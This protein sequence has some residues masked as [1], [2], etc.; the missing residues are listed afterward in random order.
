MF[1]DVQ[2][3]QRNIHTN[4]IRVWE[5]VCHLENAVKTVKYVITTTAK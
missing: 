3:G 4:K 2:R 5:L 1:G